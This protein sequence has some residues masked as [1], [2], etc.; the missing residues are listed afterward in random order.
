MNVEILIYD[1][2][3]FFSR[4]IKSSIVN[5]YSFIIAKNPEDFFCAL[6]LKEPF[7]VIFVIYSL[8]DLLNLLGTHYQTDAHMILCAYDNKLLEK[9]KDYNYLHPLD[10]NKHKND[11]LHEVKNYITF[12]LNK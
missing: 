9:A 8:E 12:F 10:L 3:L 6:K 1:P 2:Q 7:A 5:E 4:L 11:I